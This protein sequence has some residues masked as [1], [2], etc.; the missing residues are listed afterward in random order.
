MSMVNNSP[1]SPLL[2]AVSSP[3]PVLEESQ[4]PTPY[5]DL[6]FDILRT[7]RAYNALAEEPQ[8]TIPAVTAKP[9]LLEKHSKLALRCEPPQA[10]STARNGTSSLHDIQSCWADLT[11]R[12]LEKWT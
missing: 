11:L 6:D 9:V 4:R 1:R 8:T 2:S 3:S 7:I 5:S 12:Y 10:R